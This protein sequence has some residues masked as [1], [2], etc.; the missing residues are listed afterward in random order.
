[1]V[2]I[3]VFCTKL[4]AA[5]PVWG[6]TEFPC[7]VD[8]VGCVSPSDGATPQCWLPLGAPFIESALV[9]LLTSSLVPNV[10]K[11]KFSSNICLLFQFNFLPS[12]AYSAVITAETLTLYIW[13][14]KLHLT[15]EQRTI[16]N[17]NCY[18][19]LEITEVVQL[20]C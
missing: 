13:H 14:A 9:T 15:V 11:N 6:W 8:G 12:T 4:S 10:K 16:L 20:I 18:L 19:T 17:S 2:E 1:M 5:L 3:S 7:M